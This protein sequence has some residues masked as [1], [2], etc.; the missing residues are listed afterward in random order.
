[1]ILLDLGGENMAKNFFTPLRYPGG[2]NKLFHYT[3]ELIEK[4]NLTGC[5]YIEPFAGGS[6][7]AMSLLFDNVVN[8]I[9][10]NDIDKSIFA[11]W[12]SVLHST[13][14]LC[15]L[16]ETTPITMEEWH[17]Q[18]NIQNNKE[19]ESLLILGFSTFFL[20]RTNRSGILLGGVIG[21]KQQTGLYKIDC[22]F[23]KK[24]L[25]KRIRA[26][27]GKKDFISIY[28]LDAIDFIE[29]VILSETNTSFIF[30]DPPY[31]NKGPGLYLNYYKHDDHC[32]LADIVKN[33]IMHPWVVTYDNVKP[34]KELYKNFKLSEFNLNYSAQNK[35]VGKEVM[36]YSNQL[37]PVTFK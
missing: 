8:N 31:Y 26:I 2:K 16:I 28:N 36:I 14:E 27:A 22:R 37:C 34:I 23:N 3:K 25:I 20:N 24:D 29:K 19:H 1:M 13:D 32:H 12:H 35:Y 33:S 15:N 18:K 30:L 10:L 5:T 9:I 6:G 17:K 4:N 7:L 11:F 21:G